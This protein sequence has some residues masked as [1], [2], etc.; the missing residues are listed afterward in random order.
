MNMI[1]CEAV[2]DLLPDLVGGRLDPARAATVRLHLRE[3]A[4]CA[5]E[6]AL[7]ASLRHGRGLP[8]DAM[9][10]QI[11]GAVFKPRPKSVRPLF[12][13]AATLALALLGGSLLFLRPDTTPDSLAPMQPVAEAEPVGAGWVGVDAALVSGA[14][15][16]RE[17]TVEELEQLLVEVGS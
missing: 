9:V 12:A 17:L 6:R 3:C 2:T 7:L 4:D 11:I 10:E 5:A 16:L 15:S 8:E 1:D 14:A 13:L